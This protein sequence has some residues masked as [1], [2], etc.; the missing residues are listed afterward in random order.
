MSE[1]V[2]NSTHRSGQ[3]RTRTPLDSSGGPWAGGLA[4]FAGALMMTL[5]VFQ[6]IQGLVALLDDTFYV[7]TANYTFEFDVTAWGW[8]HL[9]FGTM[10]LIAGYAVIGGKLWARVIGI[11]LASLSAIANFLWIP[12][13]PL[14]SLLIIALDVAVIWALCVYR[15][16]VRAEAPGRVLDDRS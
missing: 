1:K 11:V 16:S 3:V 9:V 6:V 2:S 13:Y 10:L 8:I 7:V 12:Y 15:P 5:G 4:M 14:W